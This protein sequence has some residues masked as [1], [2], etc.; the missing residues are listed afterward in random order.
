MRVDGTRLLLVDDDEHTRYIVRRTLRKLADLH[1]REAASGEEAMRLLE[2][3]EV[4]CVLTDFNMGEKNGV[5]VLCYAMERQPR[6]RRVLMSGT[7]PVAMLRVEASRECV[8]HVFEKPMG[9][10]EWASTLR[11]ALRPVVPAGER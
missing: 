10:D 7:L 2:A 4:D 5:D 6:A 8:D 11:E 3:G 9:L 1:V